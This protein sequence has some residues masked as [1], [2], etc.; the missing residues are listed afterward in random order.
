MPKSIKLLDVFPQDGAEPLPPAWAKMEAK[1]PG[2]AIGR[3]SRI[4]DS[5]GGLLW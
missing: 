2:S 3:K 1:A 4:I 5:R